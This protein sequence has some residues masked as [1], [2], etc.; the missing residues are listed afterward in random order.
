M[1]SSSPEPEP[2]RVAVVG[3]GLTG[4]A[5]AWRLLSLSSYV[6]EHLGR[7]VHV[8]LLESSPTVGGR[9]TSASVHVADL[10]DDLVVD[11]GPPM[12]HI[13]GGNDFFGFTPH[14]R[15][16]V[17]LMNDLFQSGRIER[18]EGSFGQCS[19][20]E[21]PRWGA[22]VYSSNF[23]ALDGEPPDLPLRRAMGLLET[24]PVVSLRKSGIRDQF[25]RERFATRPMAA[26]PQLVLQLHVRMQ[27][28]YPVGLVSTSKT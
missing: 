26:L 13:V 25:I 10:P 1:A 27:Y 16:M 15:S 24:N 5:C 19:Y 22:R 14:N 12:F 18:W 7:A 4:C 21:P 17:P 3:G 2:L 20:N 8:T 23:R 28:M 11:W 9:C 6:R